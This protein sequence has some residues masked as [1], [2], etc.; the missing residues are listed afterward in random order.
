[1]TVKE[2]IQELNK[3]NEDIEV[4]CAVDT[5]YSLWAYPVSSIAIRNAYE[6]GELSEEGSSK[7]LCIL[8]KENV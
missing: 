2:L 3:Y 8:L 4:S 1:M 5:S 7:R 6:D